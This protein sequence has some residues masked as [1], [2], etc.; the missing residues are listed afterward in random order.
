MDYNAAEQVE[1][2][3]GARSCALCQ[4]VVEPVAENVGI[5]VEDASCLPA[6]CQEC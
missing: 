3:T 6:Y 5:S 1:C 2:E 4:L